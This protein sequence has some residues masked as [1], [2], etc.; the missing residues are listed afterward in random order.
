LVGKP[1]D[2]NVKVIKKVPRRCYV[3]REVGCKGV[4]GRVHCPVMK[5]RIAPN[6]DDGVV[7]SDKPKKKRRKRQCQVCATYGQSGMNCSIGTSNKEKCKYFYVD[8][9]PKEE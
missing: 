9:K 5:K 8:G 4:G 3:C 1:P 7:V 2:V 6:I